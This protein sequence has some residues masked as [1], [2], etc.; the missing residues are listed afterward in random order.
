MSLLTALIIKISHILA[1]I[2]F[3]C[4][5]NVLD[6][7]WKIFNTKFVPRWKDSENSYSLRQVLALFCKLTA[8]TLS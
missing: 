8:L 3:I 1:E 2:Y 4:I 7:T 5:R 6:Q